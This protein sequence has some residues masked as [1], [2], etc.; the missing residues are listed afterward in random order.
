MKNIIILTF[1]I[2]LC[3]CSSSERSKYY[4][5]L[6]SISKQVAGGVKAAGTTIVENTAKVPIWYLQNALD[7]VKI[8]VGNYRQDNKKICVIS[9]N[10][11]SVIK[12]V[13]QNE[14]EWKKIVK[15]REIALK[16]ES[17]GDIAFDHGYKYGW[18]FYKYNYDPYVELDSD[19]GKW[20]TGALQA[21]NEIH[22]ARIAFY[23]SSLNTK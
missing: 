8:N 22:L 10:E 13:R 19:N 20:S 9:K 1:I 18:D 15:N 2:L 3:S 4:R 17:S 12:F 21:I 7:D 6:R 11:M 14:E 16:D 23:K 5:E